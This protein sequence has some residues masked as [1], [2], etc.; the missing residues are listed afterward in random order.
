MI[1][2]RANPKHKPWVGKPQL[3]SSNAPTI[4]SSKSWFSDPFLG[5]RDLPRFCKPFKPLLFNRRSFD[6]L[7]WNQTWITLMDS[8]VSWASFSRMCRV[9]FGV[10]EK[11]ALRISSCFALMVVRGP[12]RFPFGPFS[13]SSSITDSSSSFGASSLSVSVFSGDSE[14]K[15]KNAWRLHEIKRVWNSTQI[16]V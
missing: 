4:P 13:P 1:S 2:K 7:F 16:R 11:A 14:S 10:A 5:V 8:P 3:G 9:G 6:L 15:K 12:R